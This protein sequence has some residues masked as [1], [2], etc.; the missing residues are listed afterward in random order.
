MWRPRRRRFSQVP[1]VF[2]KEEKAVLETEKQGPWQDETEGNFPSIGP[3]NMET[4]G[5][6]IPPNMIPVSNVY[7]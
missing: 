2:K 6:V 3:H 7:C 1:E 4:T 5:E